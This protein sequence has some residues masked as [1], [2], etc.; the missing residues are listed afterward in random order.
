LPVRPTMVSRVREWACTLPNGLVRRLGHK[1]KYPDAAVCTARRS[2]YS[3]RHRHGISYPPY[4]TGKTRTSISISAFLRI[5]IGEPARTQI[6]VQ[7]AS[8]Q[9]REAVGNLQGSP[10]PRRGDHMLEE[11][12][13][14]LRLNSKW[15]RLNGDG[16]S[17]SLPALSGSYS[18]LRSSPGLCVGL[19]MLQS[20][21]RSLPSLGSPFPYGL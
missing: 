3:T 14:F 13:S 18:L 2:K 15:Y 16:V 7:D 6:R 17:A 20:V 19:S 21:W 12:G 10:S 4:S 1:E 8:R 9:I 11:G 5:Y